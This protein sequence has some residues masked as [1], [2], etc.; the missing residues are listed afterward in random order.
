MVEPQAQNYVPERGDIV[1][2]EFDPQAGHEQSGRRP[3]LV[4]S[5]QA[6]N[7]KTS[8]A[9]ICPITNKINGY[10]FEVALP[11]KQKV[12][13][14]VLADQIKSLDWRSRKAKFAE[15]ARSEVLVEVVAKIQTLLPV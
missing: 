8:L 6:Y 3:A 1:W 15:K 5:P 4:I 12:T 7:G 11:G 9:I 2:L 14:V 13:G 10:P